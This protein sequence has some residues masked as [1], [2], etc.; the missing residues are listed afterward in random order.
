M[1]SGPQHDRPK[2][3][4]YL[5]RARVVAS[6]IVSK[7]AGL[8]RIELSGKVGAVL[9]RDEGVV[10]MLDM[11]DPRHPKVVGRYT[12]D[13]QDSFDGDL[14]FSHD[15]RFLFYARQTHQFSKDGVHVLD[16]SDPAQPALTFYQASGGTLRIAYYFDGDSEWVIFLDAVDGLVISR[17]VRESGSLAEVFRDPDPPTKKV[18]GPSSAGLFVDPKDPATGAPILYVS[19]GGSGLEIY[20]L[21]DPTAPQMVGS[22]ADVG[23]AEVEIKRSSDKRLVY[24]A[25]E[26]WF[27]PQIPPAIVVLNATKFDAIKKVRTLRLEVP[28]DDLWRVQAMAWAGKR[29][30]VAHSHAGLVGFTPKGRMSARALLGGPHHEGAGVLSAAYAMDVEQRGKLTYLTDAATGALHTLRIAP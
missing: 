1:H 17:F 5:C 29:L 7:E 10:A 27:D 24:A 3:H 26:Y 25:T 15:G 20:D 11:A 19:T 22:W 30:L 28:V 14:A 18:G 4:R 21:S 9:Q 2:A 6:T 16:V 23:L 12:D 8:G 13:A